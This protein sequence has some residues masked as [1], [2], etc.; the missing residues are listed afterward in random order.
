MRFL[1]LLFVVLLAASCSIQKRHYRPGFFVQLAAHEKS[2]AQAFSGKENLVDT[3]GQQQATASTDLIALPSSPAADAIQLAGK[4][5][6]NPVSPDTLL[7]EKKAKKRLAP[8]PWETPDETKKRGQHKRE[9]WYGFFLVIAGLLVML[10]FGFELGAIST[11]SGLILA[12]IGLVIM[13]IAL[14]SIARGKARLRRREKGLPERNREKG[15]TI[16]KSLLVLGVSGV[17]GIV[18]AFVFINNINSI[19]TLIFFLLLVP[20]AIVF[21]IFLLILIGLLIARLIQKKIAKNGNNSDAYAQYLSLRQKYLIRAIAALGCLLASILLLLVG[22][23]LGYL[24][25]TLSAVVAIYYFVKL[26]MLKNPTKKPD[27][28]TASADVFPLRF[29][30]PNG[31]A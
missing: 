4:E 9:A 7:P 21:Q 5:I 15:L 28:Q 24:M 11:M 13:L 17:I 1:T 26:F 29:G 25:I 30:P 2:T 14:L 18:C 22:G 27:S 6:V 31:Q 3:A 23:L 10:F 19:G 20:M 12:I 16:R 8:L